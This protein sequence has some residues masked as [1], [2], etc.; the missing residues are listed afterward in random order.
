MD[1]PASAKGYG[2]MYVPWLKVSKPSW[3]RGEQ[4]VKLTGNDRRKLSK[5]RTEDGVKKEV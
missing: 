3:F 1:I 5:V 4:S 2:A